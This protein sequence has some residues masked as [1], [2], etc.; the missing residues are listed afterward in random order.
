QL[1]KRFIER[2]ALRKLVLG[3][4]LFLRLRGRRAILAVL[5]AFATARLHRHAFDDTTRHVRF[6]ALSLVILTAPLGCGKA[7]R[8]HKAAGN[9]YLRRGDLDRALHEFRTAAT[10]APKDPAAHTLLGDVLF[11][12]GSLGEAEQ[13]YQQALRLLPGATDAHRGLGAIATRRG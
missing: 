6:L 10:L 11:E 9:M 12:I 2:F 1:A 4:C 3:R 8:V 7:D 13:E 5:V